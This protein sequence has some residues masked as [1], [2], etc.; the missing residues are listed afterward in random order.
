MT[1]RDCAKM[2]DK[3]ISAASQCVASS[4]RLSI[5]DACIE[6]TQIGRFGKIPDAN[7]LQ[8][9]TFEKKAKTGEFVELTP[10]ALVFFRQLRGKELYCAHVDEDFALSFTDGVLASPGLN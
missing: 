3:N 2:M 6:N 7:P 8:Y 4:S 1:K 5:E 9:F 10:F